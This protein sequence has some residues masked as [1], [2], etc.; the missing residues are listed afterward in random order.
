M[1]IKRIVDGITIPDFKLYYRTVVMKTG[2]WNENRH[3]NQCNTIENTD[4]SLHTYDHLTFDKEHTLKKMTASSTNG[5]DK[6][7]F[8]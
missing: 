2:Y 6:T 5:V 3:I 7:S 4:I 8:M 1:G